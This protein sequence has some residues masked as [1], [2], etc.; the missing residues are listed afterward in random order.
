M[1]RG[2]FN[3]RVTIPCFAAM[4]HSTPRQQNFP[5]CSSLLRPCVY[6]PL[7]SPLIHSALMSSFTY[8]LPFV[9]RALP[10]QQYAIP[11]FRGCPRACPNV[12]FYRRPSSRGDRR[13]LF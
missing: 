13:V 3:F 8:H 12:V 7:K 1:S 9:D 6:S 10:R 4:S 5:F 2:T 11:D